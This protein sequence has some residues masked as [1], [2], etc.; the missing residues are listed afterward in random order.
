M[1]RYRLFDL[2]NGSRVCLSTIEKQCQCK[3]ST[4]VI[5]LYTHKSNGL[6]VFVECDKCMTKA[7]LV[8]KP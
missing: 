3:D 7:M 6:M 2:V 8:S 1:Y 4:L 5:G